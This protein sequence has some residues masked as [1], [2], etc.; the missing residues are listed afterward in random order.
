MSESSQPHHSAN[1]PGSHYQPA[2]SVVLI[3]VVLF[4]A[5]AFLMLRYV[6]P[7]SN[8]SS[9]TTSSTTTTTIHHH[10]VAKSTVRVQ[11]ANG[12][13]VFNLA[14]GYSQEL[15]TQG[16]NTLPGVNGPHESKTIVY[17]NPGFKWAAIQISHKIH[18]SLHS[19]QALN[20]QRPVPGASSDDVIVILGHNSANKG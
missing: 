10:T 9:V 18:V 19:I 17:F 4:V 11:V 5:A 7:A 8:A 16:W 6:S 15:L 1:P 13:T 12:T 2:L 14:R 20:G 3:I